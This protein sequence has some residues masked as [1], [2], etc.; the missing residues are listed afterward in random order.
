MNSDNNRIAI[1]KVFQ[2]EGAAGTL[3]H[4]QTCVREAACEALINNL[5]APL[6]DCYVET[7]GALKRWRGEL[8]DIYDTYLGKEESK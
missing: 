6:N 5:P 4:L 7:L 3:L 8:D 1:R 2:E